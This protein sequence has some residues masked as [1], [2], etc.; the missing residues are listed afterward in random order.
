MPQTF[1][2]MF[3]VQ[4]MPK[5]IRWQ[6]WPIAYFNVL[7]T[8]LF[9]VSFSAC[10]VFYSLIFCP[11]SFNI[12]SSLFYTCPFNIFLCLSSFTYWFYFCAYKYW[13]YFY[14]ILFI[15]HRFDAID[16]TLLLVF[17]QV[18]DKPMYVNRWNERIK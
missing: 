15:G 18:I 3:T 9:R 6:Y 1:L 2:S 5:Q 17:I 16:M 11:L 14:F 4:W 13:F 12:I 10:T 7:A 8:T